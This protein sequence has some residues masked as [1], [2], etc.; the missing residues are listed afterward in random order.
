MTRKTTLS[1]RL[2]DDLKQRWQALCLRQGSTPSDGLR[3]VIVRLL[4]GPTTDTPPTPSAH[5]QPDTSRRRLELRLT[6]TEYARTCASSITRRRG[7]FCLSSRFSTSRSAPA[8]S[9]LDAP[10]SASIEPSAPASLAL[11]LS[12]LTGLPSFVSTAFTP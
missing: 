9:I 7:F 5:E 2:D 12:F 11:A 6:E 10:S 3:Q 1:I 4:N 8:L